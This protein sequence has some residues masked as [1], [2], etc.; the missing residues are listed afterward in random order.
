MID[1]SESDCTQPVKS[2]WPLSNF[3]ISYRK[4]IFNE[5]SLAPLCFYLLYKIQVF[6]SNLDL[7]MTRYLLKIDFKVFFVFSTKNK[8]LQNY[9]EL[10][11]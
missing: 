4:I 5:T 3:F 9:S 6:L 7:S 2:L 11:C 1:C 8:N 10:S